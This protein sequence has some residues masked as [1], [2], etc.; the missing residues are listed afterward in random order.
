MAK[1]RGESRECAPL[2]QRVVIARSASGRARGRDETPIDGDS[3]T[4]QCALPRKRTQGHTRSV[5][6]R[7]CEWIAQRCL[8]LSRR[9]LLTRSRSAQL[10]LTLMQ[11]DLTLLCVETR[12][13]QAVA[14]FCSP[15][16][17]PVAAKTHALSSAIDTFSRALP[18]LSCSGASP[19][20]RQNTT[21]RH[22]ADA[23]RFSRDRLRR[24]RARRQ[25][26]RP[27]PRRPRPGALS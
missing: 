10:R 6:E 26:R 16:C 17:L 22:D 11:S 2:T 9:P 27:A 14:F 23:A 4:G 1:T 21:Q 18:Q 7:R 12:V 13:L 15:E 8:T 25:G 24:A 3:T 20:L 5:G 19:F